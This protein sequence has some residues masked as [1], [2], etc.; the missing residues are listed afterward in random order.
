MTP[1][2]W[3]NIDDDEGAL[4]ALLSRVCDH[5]P[6]ALIDYLWI[7]PP[8]RVAAGESIVF[9]V[10]AFGDDPIRRR[11]LTAHFTISRNRKGQAFVNA[12]FDEHGSAPASAVPRIVDG[13]LHRL[14]EDADTSLREQQ[15]GGDP[16]QWNA[17][18][19]ELGGRPLARAT[20]PSNHESA[21]AA[22]PATAPTLSAAPPA[23]ATD[24]TTI[25]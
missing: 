4:H 8:R 2:Q 23:A 17:L 5:V 24:A 12:R 6:I 7:F 9:V 18:V 15:I 11:V 3:A 20:A 22:R 21:P 13:V 14:G 10:A 25:G 19:I 1:Q 16:E